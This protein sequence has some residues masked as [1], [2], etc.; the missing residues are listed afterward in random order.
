MPTL[1]VGQVSPIFIHRVCLIH[2]HFDKS[3]IPPL[4]VYVE[5]TPIGMTPTSWP[6]WYCPSPYD[7]RVEEALECVILTFSKLG[8]S[9]KLGW[10][11]KWCMRWLLSVIVGNIT[12]KYDGL[13]YAPLYHLFIDMGLLTLFSLMRFQADMCSHITPI[14]LYEVDIFLPPMRFRVDMCSLCGSRLGKAPQG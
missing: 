2:V 14:S 5:Y 7:Q 13:T 3:G 11:C 12:G 9:P 1:A 6:C 4:F 10:G 8:I